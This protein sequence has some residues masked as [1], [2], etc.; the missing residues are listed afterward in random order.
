MKKTLIYITLVIAAFVVIFSAFIVPPMIAEG[1]SSARSRA[2]WEARRRQDDERNLYLMAQLPEYFAGSYYHSRWRDDPGQL[3][4]LVV[5][6]GYL[7]A[8]ELSLSA[9]AY[10]RENVD[11]RDVVRPR[12]VEFTYAQLLETKAAVIAEMEARPG[13]VYVDNISGPFIS[14][15]DNRVLMETS[16][17]I[18]MDYRDVVA[19][20]IRHVY[21]SEMIEFRRAFYLPL[22]GGQG[23]LVPAVLLSLLIAAIAAFVILRILEKRKAKREQKMAGI[24]H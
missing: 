6:G 16:S 1:I 20:F 3:I 9:D 19:G 5:E 22:G 7:A 10:I 8:R 14:V 23:S 18:Q 11:R 15:T 12:R 2:Y 24:T 4:I 21:N 13:C 17:L